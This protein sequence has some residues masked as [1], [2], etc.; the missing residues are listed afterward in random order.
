MDVF[1][2]S[3]GALTKHFLALKNY[4]NSIK[5]NRDMN[6]VERKNGEA[7]VLWFQCNF[8]E[9]SGLKKAF[10]VLSWRAHNFLLDLHVILERNAEL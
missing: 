5:H 6:V 4:R 10:K 8:G 1:C 3:R 7:A 9:E 2:K